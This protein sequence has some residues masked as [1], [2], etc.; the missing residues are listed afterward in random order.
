MENPAS[1]LI[2]DEGEASLNQIRVY[3][4]KPGTELPDG[5]LRESDDAETHTIDSHGLRGYLVVARPLPRRPDWLPFIEEVLGTEIP[6]A[7]N[8]HI[9]SVLLL[10]RGDKTFALTF[11]FGRHLLDPNALEPDFGLRT[12]AGLIDPAAIA[13]V[14]SRA[15]EATVLQVRRQSS[16][17]TGTRAIGLDVG[18][19][20]LRAIAGEL[21]D[22]S[23]GTRVTGSD[24]LGLT[25]ALEASELGPRLDALG[26]AFSERRYVRSFSYLDR[27]P[28]K[29]RRSSQ[30]LC[31]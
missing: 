27:W 31:G 29:C 12:A 23:L 18:R 20:M 3:L 4:I 17:G 8:S 30:R 10:Q 28:V 19:E 14:D 5:A 13:S 25:A 24:S 1:D 15:F 16:R 21:L 6:Y 2:A 9:S 11:G 22:E 7:G 26:A